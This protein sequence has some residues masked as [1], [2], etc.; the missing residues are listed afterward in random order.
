MSEELD[1]L[2]NVCQKLDEAH[3]PYMITGSIA[4]NFYA[5][6]RMTR[7][8]DIVIEI[9]RKDIG[10]IEKLFKK[11]FFVD[12]EMIEEAIEKEGMFNIIHKEYVMKV[13]L[14]I[15]KKSV[16]RE[17]EFKRKRLVDLGGKKIFI[18][19]PEDLILSK[20]FWAKDSFSE[21][22]LGDV[23][24]LM[25]T[26]N[27]LDFAYLEQWVHALGLEEVYKKVKP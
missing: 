10:E 14:I 15:R 1:I 21:L 9:R 20:L 6:P 4:S 11:E 13:D 19:S 3:L 8:I 16:Y 18:V 24:N 5:V 12:R 23:K 2:K 7:D 25:R 22:Q 26:L 27:D 17:L